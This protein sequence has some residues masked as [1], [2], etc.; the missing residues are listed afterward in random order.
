MSRD[1][2]IRFSRKVI[3]VSFIMCVFVLYIHAKYYAYCDFGDVH[4]MLIY[5]LKSDNV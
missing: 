5:V 1:V 4:G 2:S 3:I